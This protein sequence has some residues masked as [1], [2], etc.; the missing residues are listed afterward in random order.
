MALSVGH[1]SVQCYP[2]LRFFRA[3]AGVLPRSQLAL[4]KPK[5]KSNE[6][7]EFRI[8]LR[9]LGVAAA[10]AACVPLLFSLFLMSVKR[11]L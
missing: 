10:A 11:F 7:T 5:A 8:Y 2:V 3:L 6:V 9:C 4:A 1:S